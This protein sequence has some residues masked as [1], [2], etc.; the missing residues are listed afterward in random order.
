MPAMSMGFEVR[1]DVSPLHAGDRIV[2][3]LVLSDSHSWLEDV[4]VTS[5]DGAAGMPSPARRALPGAI[6][7]DSL[8]VDQDGAPF[9]LRG[10]G[11]VRIVTFLYTRCPL[12]DFCPLMI[13]H[14]EGVRRRANDDGLASRLSLVGVTLDPAFDTPAALRAYGQSMLKGSN[15]FDQWTLATGTAAQIEDVARFFGVGYRAEG[16][17]VTH[18]LATA[19]LSAEGRVVRVFESNSWRPDDVYDLVRRTIERTVR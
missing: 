18:T 16:G 7:P 19:V 13:Q 3:T 8:L 17:L 9:T 4:K 14:L 1:G 2:A 6:V 15:R 10:G 11:R 5:R 12:P